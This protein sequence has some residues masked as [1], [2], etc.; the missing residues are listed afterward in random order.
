MR[1]GTQYRL[2]IRVCDLA[3]PFVFECCV[4]TVNHNR[5]DKVSVTAVYRSPS[6]NLDSFIDLFE[7]FT[8]D[9]S[10]SKNNFLVCDDFNV[11]TLKEDRTD[12][13]LMW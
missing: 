7:P 12:S 10:Q 11:D 4:V 1:R 9:L 3:A 5:A 6:S 13:L 2:E 8:D